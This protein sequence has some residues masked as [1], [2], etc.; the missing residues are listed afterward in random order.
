MSKTSTPSV[1]GGHF[2]LET[3]FAAVRLEGLAKLADTGKLSHSV[4]ITKTQ[5]L[6]C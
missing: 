2:P 6:L 5:E 1:R 3:L 4:A